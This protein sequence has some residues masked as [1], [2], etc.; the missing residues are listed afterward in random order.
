MSDLRGAQEKGYVRHAPSYNS[1]FDYL[2]NPELSPL[3]T[4]LIVEASRPLAAIESDFA[5]DSTGFASSRFIKWYDHKY[6]VVRQ[7]HDWVKAHFICGVKTNVVTSVEIHERNAS[8][9]PQ[10]P[11]LLDR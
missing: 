10:L 2:E 3:L 4:N 11:S 1:I 8:D 7:D 9:T 5:I 6:N